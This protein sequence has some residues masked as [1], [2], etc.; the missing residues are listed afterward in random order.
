MEHKGTDIFEE[1]GE[2]KDRDCFLMC[3]VC[4]LDVLL[5]NLSLQR[6]KHCT[7]PYINTYLVRRETIILLCKF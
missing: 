2:Q 6:Y 5:L 4:Y 3:W 1:E 7:G